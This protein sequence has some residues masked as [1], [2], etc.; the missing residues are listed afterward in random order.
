MEA[1]QIEENQPEPTPPTEL[2][3]AA[4]VEFPGTAPTEVPPPESS[5]PNWGRLRDITADEPSFDASQKRRRILVGLTAAV[6]ITLLVLLLALLWRAVGNTGGFMAAIRNIVGSEQPAPEESKPT[7]AQKVQKRGKGAVRGQRSESTPVK[8]GNSGEQ[9]EQLGPFEVS[10][11]VENRRVI[12]RPST[13]IY[14]VDLRTGAVFAIIDE[15]TRI[16]LDPDRASKLVYTVNPQVPAE[17]QRPRM[18]GE[19][20][21]RAIVEKDGTIRSVQF[22]TGTRELADPAIQAVRQWRYEPYYYNGL[23]IEREVLIRIIVSAAQK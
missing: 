1:D 16:Q 10:A 8:A 11:M 22:V 6:V 17:A 14:R 9:G 18:E 4:L 2:P 13:S 20:L 3:T 21:V 5:E 15:H 7:D 12:P 19:V 23:P